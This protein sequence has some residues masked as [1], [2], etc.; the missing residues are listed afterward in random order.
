MPKEAEACHVNEV[1]DLSIVG[2]L[3]LFVWIACLKVEEGSLDEVSEGV[4]K[5]A[6]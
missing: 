6:S 2:G 1:V 4:A 3:E 5:E